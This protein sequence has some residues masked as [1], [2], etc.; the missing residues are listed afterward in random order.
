MNGLKARLISLKDR[1]KGHLRRKYKNARRELCNLVADGMAAHSSLSLHSTPSLSS[2]SS[3]VRREI[4]CS[5]LLSVDTIDEQLSQE[6]S[7]FSSLSIEA[8]DE[9]LSHELSSS[10]LCV[11]TVVEQLSQE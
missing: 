8:M 9:Q 7:S 6:L 5:S 11:N 1:V 2:S 4:P 3:P 10:L